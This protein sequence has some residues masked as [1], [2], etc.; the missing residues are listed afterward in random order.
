LG[1][2]LRQFPHGDRSELHSSMFGWFA[3]AIEA[4][5]SAGYA[6]ARDL[7]PGTIYAFEPPAEA[8]ATAA[9]AGE[10]DPFPGALRFRK[11]P[12]TIEAVRF[13]HVDPTSRQILFGVTPPP[14]WLI[15]ACSGPEGDVG[16]VWAREDDVL[17]GTL[18][19]HYVAS[20]G[21]WIIR[22]V[23]NEVYACKPAIF[24][25]TYE[26]A[27]GNDDATLVSG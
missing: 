4:G 8:V 21:D 10:A 27:D 6:A 11:L 3:N 19:G 24:A 14:E 12:V 2:E 7:D 20:P 16:S 1:K 23:K 9:P 25:E 22:G 17:I 26:R 15:D 18:E 5:R 13:L